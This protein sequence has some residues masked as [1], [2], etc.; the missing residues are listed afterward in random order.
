MSNEPEFS[1]DGKTSKE[2]YEMFMLRFRRSLY[3]PTQRREMM[4][5]LKT[6][7]LDYIPVRSTYLLDTIFKSLTSSIIHDSYKEI[8]L[9]INYNYPD[10][11][12]ELSGYQR[13]ERIETP[14]HS[15]DKGY[16]IIYKPTT[17]EAIARHSP[18][19]GTIKGNKQQYNL[20][21]PDAVINVPLMIESEIEIAFINKIVDTFDGMNIKCHIEWV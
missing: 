11:M 3:N 4:N 6:R 16:G 1:I 12:P 8:I 7:I 13:P 9:V 19:A 21:D 2:I 14:R 5:D 15:G 17:S 18:I 10:D 20:N